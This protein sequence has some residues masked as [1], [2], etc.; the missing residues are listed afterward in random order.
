METRKRGKKAGRVKRA[1]KKARRKNRL[2]SRMRNV[3]KYVDVKHEGHNNLKIWYV[4][5]LMIFITYRY[6]LN[7]E[8]EGFTSYKDTE[9][10]QLP[11]AL[12]DINPDFRGI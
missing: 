5:A 4:F 11:R 1:G 2:L 8:K 12:F 7:T 3:Y 10:M 9:D 6:S